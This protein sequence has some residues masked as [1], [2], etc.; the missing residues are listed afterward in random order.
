MARRKKYKKLERYNWDARDGLQC[1]R[2]NSSE[3]C[4]ES[5]IW[6]DMY[7]HPNILCFDDSGNKV[8]TNL[9]LSK[10]H[11]MKYSLVNAF[12]GKMNGDT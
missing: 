5:G 2:L 10:F 12:K 7:A 11:K 4:G 8:G 6:V 1:N 3:K 9:K